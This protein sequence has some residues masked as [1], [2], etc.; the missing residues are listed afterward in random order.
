M[1]VHTLPVYSKVA[2]EAEVRKLG[3]WE[4]LPINGDGTRWR[5]SQHQ[6]ETY[7]ALTDP[8][9]P[10]VV[11]NTAMTGDGKSL[12]G[13]LPALVDGG[14][15][16][17]FAMYPT[18]ELIRDQLRQVEMSW[19]RWRQR[20]T[21]ISL[22]SAELDRRLETGDFDQRGEAL[23]SVLRNHNVVLTTPDIFH[24]IMQMFYT[25]Q[26]KSGDAP[27]KI[28]GPLLNRFQ[29]FTFDEFHIFETPQIV[30]VVN[31]LLLIDELSKGRR[32][33]FL[34]QSATPQ[35]LMV[36]YLQRARLRVQTITG[37]Y[38]HTRQQP[39]ATQWRRILQGC[40]IHFAVGTVE[41]WA[42]AHLNDVI[43]PFFCDHTPGA[44]G[45]II[46]NSV[47][48]AK[49]LVAR[50]RPALAPHHIEVSENTGLTSRRL[51]AASY[52]A[53]LLIG[54]STIDVGV[55][56]QINFLV[57]ESRDAGSFLQRL[58]RLGRH[59]GYL[60]DG[61][62]VGFG[63]TFQAYALLPPWTIETLFPD[64]ASDETALTDGMEIDRESFHRAVQSAFVPSATFEG[65]A[66]LWGCLQTARVAIGL[67]KYVV[68]GQY[69]TTLANLVQ[70]YE[71]TFGI[72]LNQQV[73]RYVALGKEEPKLLEEVTAFRGGSYFTCGVI[74]LTESGADQIKSYDLFALLANGDLGECSEDAFWATIEQQS[75][76]PAPL[77]RQEPLAF[78]QLRGFLPERTAYRVKVQHDLLDWGAERFGR[79]SLL[80]GITI[81]TDF[82]GSVPGLTA[83]NQ[84]LRRRQLPA[85]LCLGKHPQELKRRL[86]LPLLLPLYAFGSR[87][88]LSGTIVFGR[89]ALLLEVTLRYS[90][91]DC[92]SGAAMIV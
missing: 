46:V 17:L 63:G 45:A 74:D 14:L 1:Q 10:E 50:L 57:F 82:P 38:Q 48:Q 21:A 35:D 27:D 91:I 59:E 36:G 78:F 32:K 26:G 87:D 34:F 3:L 19:E 23:L 77:R 84:R 73:G 12:A 66:K 60:R 79:A 76:D 44:K 41:E 37:H 88:G 39:A 31:A 81:E 80:D 72:K 62:W 5:L 71:T 68:R 7:Q 83:I 89:P 28:I 11:I 29:Q 9:G 43:I 55:D 15:R 24:Y 49:R 61:Q 92:S 22:D 18:N 85:L 51:R 54:T 86:R 6:V 16:P 90:G 64:Q 47:A 58:G 75:V 70:R 53:D 65:Y 56:F 52:S 30:S 8:Q 20:L 40:T 67:K 13:Q 25:R 69:E 42:E 2:D 4:K 33:Q